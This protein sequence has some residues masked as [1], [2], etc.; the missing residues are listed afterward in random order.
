MKK[1]NKEKALHKLNRRNNKNVKLTTVIISITLLIGTIIYFSFARFEKTITYN[2]IDGTLAELNLNNNIATQIKKLK[3]S[4]SY[5]EYDGTSTLGELGTEDNNLRYI[6]A[7]PNN[8]IYFNCSTLNPD[9]MNDTTCEKWRIVGV[10]NNIEDENGNSASRVKIM[11]DESLGNYSWDSSESS[12]NEG[13]GVNQ[14]GESGTYEGAD[15]MRE[16]NTDYLGNITVGTDGLWYNSGNNTKT[17]SMPTT[18]INQSSQSMIETVVWNLGSPSNNNGTYDPSWGSNITPS[19]SY[20]RERA[21]SNEK[22]CTNDIYCNDTVTRTSS[23]IGKVALMHL[24]DFGY[25]TSGGSTTNKETCLS[26]SMYKWDDS[27]DCYNNSWIY[28]SSYDQWTLSPATTSDV[29]SFVFFV[30]GDGRI[31]SIDAVEIIDVRPAVFLKSD[32][33]ITSGDGSSSNPYKIVNPNNLISHITSEVQNSSYLEY[34]GTATLDTNGTSDNNLRYIGVDPNNY[35]YFNCSTTDPN[36]MNDTTCEKWRIIGLMNNIET[37]SGQTQSLLKIRRAESLGNYSWD[38]SASSINS[39]YGV[40]QWGSS[41]TYEGA[42]LMRE[43]NTDYLDNVSVGTDGKW[44]DGSSNK[45]T[46]T[47]PTS[48]LNQNAQNMIETVVWKLG[49]PSSNNGTYDSSY[50]NKIIPSTSYTRERAATNGKTCSSG[51]NCNDSVNRTTTWTGKV[52]LIYPS[53][54]GYATSGGTTSSRTTCLS[55]S[56]YSWNGSGVSDC[57]N[58]NWLFTSS[59]QWTLSPRADTSSAYGAFYIGDNGMLYNYNGADGARNVF[60]VVFLKSSI[61]I[62]EGNGTSTNPYKIA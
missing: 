56:M 59:Y 15:I 29:A 27:S 2:L 47:M 62:T 22:I 34:D 3:K 36:E 31:D 49:S 20:A 37:S 41:G 8:Y 50:T 35:I 6:G 12:I 23:W 17:K 4:S 18:T 43:L 51:N 61:S 32:L 33:S 24:S 60:P 21:D 1:F 28:N 44:Y 25:S 54:Y 14:W 42:D 9:E 55:T 30:N 45:K 46:T 58:N 40:N 52:G 38:T 19:T 57:K 5:L 26:K 39:G 13:C 7:N 53:D 48:A 16:L 10:F 11:R